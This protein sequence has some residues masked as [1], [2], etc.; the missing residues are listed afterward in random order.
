MRDAR[1]RDGQADEP[2]AA[3]LALDE[4]FDDDFD[5]VEDV[6]AELPFDDPELPLLDDPPSDPPLPA[7]DAALG[8]EEVSLVGVDSFA[9]V[10]PASDLS[11]RESVR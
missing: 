6:A 5:D 9:G 8:V 7:V 4:L 2:A 1:T 11:A 3:L 10:A